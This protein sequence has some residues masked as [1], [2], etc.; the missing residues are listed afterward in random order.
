MGLAIPL[1]DFSFDLPPQ[2]QNDVRIRF[3]A[4]LDDTPARWQFGVGPLGGHHLVATAVEIDAGTTIHITTREA[5]S[6]LL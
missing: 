3:A 2:R 4:T 5:A 6:P 1:G